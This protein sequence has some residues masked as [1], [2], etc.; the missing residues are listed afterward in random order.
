M[1]VI[2]FDDLLGRTFILPMD[3]N[4]EK[5]KTTISHHVNTINQDQISR[6]DQLRFKLKVGG[7]QLE[8]LV[9]YNQLMEYIEDNADTG[10]LQNGF[11]K[12]NCIKDHRGPYTSSDPEYLGSSYNLLIEWKTGEITW[13][14]LSNIIASDPYTCAIY[15]KRH[16]Q[17]NTPGWKLLKRHARTARRLIRT[18]KKS[19]YRQAN[20]SR[21]YKHGWE[22][23]RDYAHA[24]ELD[25]Q[26]GKNKWKDAIDLEI[27]QIKEY[28]VFKDYGRTVYEKDKIA[29]T[30]NGYQKIRI[31]FVFDVK[32]CR[33]FKARL[34][35]DG[36]LTKESNETVFSGVVS[37][38]NL[39]LAMFLGELSNLQ[40]WG[41]DVGNAY[42][43]AL[44]KEKL[45]IVVLHCGGMTSYLISFIKLVS[46]PQ[47]QMQISG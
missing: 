36:Y 7:N 16:N 28:Q 24:L 20:V 17:L 10:Q 42:L 8:D 22:A 31:H 15:A 21:K 47:K 9:S 6:E 4:G 46:N 12:F 11:Y 29:N 32:H 23:P 25:I 40:L 43:Q 35:A 39:R 27:E 30:P 37:L 34:V 3:E 19:K 38:R 1:S 26:N 18:L 13:E 14:P 41:A 33:K 44:K 5:K 45:Y 2:K